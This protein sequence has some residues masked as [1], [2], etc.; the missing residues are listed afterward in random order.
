MVYKPYCRDT[1]TIWKCAYEITPQTMR[2]VKMM[3]WRRENNRSEEEEEGEEE[4]GK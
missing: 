4:E 2:L 1:T 3:R